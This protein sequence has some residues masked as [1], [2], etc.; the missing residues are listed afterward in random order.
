G[1]R[2]IHWCTSCQT[3]LAEA[4]IEYEM[5][6]SP[7]I[8]VKFPVQ[9]DP[10]GILGGKKGFILIW[11]TTPWTIPANLAIV[12]HPEYDYVILKTREEELYLVAQ[13]LVELVAAETHLEDYQIVARYKGRDLK[14]LICTHPFL[15]R[16]SPVLL[17]DYVTLDQGTGCVHTAP[18]H[19]RE[20]FLTGQQYGLEILCPV[21]ER[22]I[23][24]DRAGQ[25][26]GMYVEDANPLVVEAIAQ[27]GLLLKV[28]QV[29][30]QYPHCW[31]CHNPVIFRTTVQWF[32]SV[33]HQGLRQ[34]ALKEID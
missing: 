2:P 34:K 33:D 4:E 13:E 31:R 19:G 28:G 3:A 20:D 9:E 25:F 21:D 26:R 24:D 11:T 10:K 30:H 22:G 14:D 32:M 29:E 1:L 15:A 18:G 16:P 12:V 6:V 7:S 17:G 8:Y 23:F 5:K 27:N